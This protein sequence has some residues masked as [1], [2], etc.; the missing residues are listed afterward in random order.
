MCCSSQSKKAGL[1]WNEDL[2]IYT[3]WSVKLDN[4]ALIGSAW[5]LSILCVSSPVKSGGQFLVIVS[6]KG[7]QTPLFS[8]SLPSS[9]LFVASSEWNPCLG[10]ILIRQEPARAFSP[11]LVARGRGASNINHCVLESHG[12]ENKWCPSGLNVRETFPACNL[13]PRGNRV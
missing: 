3:Q 9:Q 10:D 7:G 11:A 12:R 5:H 1:I 2:I 8:R 4:G 6:V 13:G